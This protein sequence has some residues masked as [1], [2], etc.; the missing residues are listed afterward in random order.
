M[1]LP[2]RRRNA[3]RLRE[4][5]AVT[6]ISAHD[7]NELAVATWAF[8]HEQEAG[9]GSETLPAAAARYVPL[10]TARGVVGVIGVKPANPD[11]V[12]TQEEHSLLEAFASLA[13]LAIERVHLAE[14][15]RNAQVVAATEKLQT[16]LLNSISH[17][18]RTPL[19]SVTGALSTLGEDGARL[20]EAT[21]RELIDTARGEAERLNRLVGNLLDMTRIEA[22]AMKIDRQP[23]DVQ[24]VIGSAL[25]ELNSR[26]GARQ[27]TV[28]VPE[29]LPLVP[30]DFVLMVQVLINLLDNALK[31]SPAGAPID[32]SARA[33][34]SRL[35]LA[36]ADRGIGIPADELE[37]VF[38]KFY[39]VQHRGTTSGTG[40]G[41][42]I[43]KGI[44]EA[45]GGE[46]RA[47]NREGGG[48]LVT[49]WLPLEPEAAATL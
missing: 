2:D 40:L 20:D 10:K 6:R 9:R 22:G 18:L 5:A 12:L 41:L 45:H 27:V 3:N 44:V 11:A 33:V 39:R 30:L 46:I 24:D 43:C 19:V 49:L 48:T 38:D 37:R 36:V 14:V 17:D 8:Q 25:E 42:S 21:R 26:L 47:E 34:G 23:S 29:D 35:E 7:E 13:A 16:A 28:D 31:Y 32:V 1:M 15:A 4:P